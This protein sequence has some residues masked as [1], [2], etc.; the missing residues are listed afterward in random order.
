VENLFLLGTSNLNGTGNELANKLTGTSGTNTLDGGLGADTLN[1]GAGND[2]YVVDDA[3]DTVVE[4]SA[5]GAPPTRCA[6]RWRATPLG[7]MSRT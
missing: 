5:S 2:I 4:E 7:P 6:R 1:G 3:G